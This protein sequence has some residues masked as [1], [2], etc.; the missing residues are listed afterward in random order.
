LVTPEQVQAVRDSDAIAN[1]SAA[2]TADE[3]KQQFP[4][5]Q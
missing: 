3:L 1:R 2:W 5:S 4:E